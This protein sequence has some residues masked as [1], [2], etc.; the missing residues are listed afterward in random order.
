MWHIQY[1]SP[2][3]RISALRPSLSNNQC[4][5]QLMYQYHLTQKDAAKLM[6]TSLY[7]LR[8]WLIG[9]E[10]M[11]KYHLDAL[12]LEIHLIGKPPK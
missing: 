6:Q 11:T 1:K 5:K 10:A 3:A 4:L 9:K 12:Q 8:K 2:Q 7:Q